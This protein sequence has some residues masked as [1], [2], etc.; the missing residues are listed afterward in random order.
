MDRRRFIGLSAAIAAA[1]LA[2]AC[3]GQEKVPA[4]GVPRSAFDED[5]PPRK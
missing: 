1:P 2:T 3:S 5:Q 4:A